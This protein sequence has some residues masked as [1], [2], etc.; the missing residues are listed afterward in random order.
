MWRTDCSS[1][2]KKTVTKAEVSLPIEQGKLVG[3]AMASP[4]FASREQQ[5]EKKKEVLADFLYALLSLCSHFCQRLSVA[6]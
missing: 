2:L 4:F 3:S 6:F 5:N 1:L